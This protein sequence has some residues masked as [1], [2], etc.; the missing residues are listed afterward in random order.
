M[1][2]GIGRTPVPRSVI[3]AA[4]VHAAVV[5]VA[6][7][8]VLVVTAVLTRGRPFHCADGSAG[9]LS[10]TQYVLVYVPPAIVASGAIGAFVRTLLVW[11]RRGPWMVWLAAGWFLFATMIV[12]VSI[13]GGALMS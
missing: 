10:A 1:G 11:R 6:A 12:F 2:W 7:V 5:I 8:I 4:V 13:A 3:R 9:C